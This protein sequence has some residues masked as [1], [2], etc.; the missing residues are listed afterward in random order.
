MRGQAL[1]ILLVIVAGVGV[2]VMSVSTYD[3]LQQTRDRFYRDTRFAHIFANLTRAPEAVAEPVTRWPEVAAVETRIT[4]PVS[5]TI[6]LSGIPVPLRDARLAATY[7]G[8][9]AQTVLNGLLM[10]FIS[11]TD[12]DNTILPA[13]LP[14]IGG[15]PLSIVLPG[16]DPAGP[17]RNCATFSDKDTN[18]GV[19][20]WWFY[21]NFSAAKVPYTP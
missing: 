10:G 4:A 21:L 15:K 8:N 3:S 6:T 18:N 14:L 12:A 16:G 20:G 11:E 1:A 7:S 13:N 19:V 9:P 2:C 17:D 5:L